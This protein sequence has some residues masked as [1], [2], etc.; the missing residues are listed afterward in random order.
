MVV[1]LA[2]RNGCVMDCHATTRGSIFIK[3]RI[4]VK[5]IFEHIRKFL[6]NMHVLDLTHIYHSFR[7]R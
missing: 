1:E 2:W 5:K 6:Y 7:Y 4:S 3:Y